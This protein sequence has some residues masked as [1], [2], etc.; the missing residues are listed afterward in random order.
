MVP[1]VVK[2]CIVFFKMCQNNLNVIKNYKILHKILKIGFKNSMPP[3]TPVFGLD[4][5]YPTII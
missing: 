1:L 2:S 3:E 5:P 4:E